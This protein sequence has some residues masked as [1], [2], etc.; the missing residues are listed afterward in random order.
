[1]SDKPGKN[2]LSFCV[3]ILLLIQSQMVHAVAYCALRDPVMAIQA[4]YPQYSSYR[5]LVGEVGPE[6]RSVLEQEIPYH[7]HFNEFGKH[8]LYLVFEGD[9]AAGLV[10]AR[11]EKGDWG[12]D[13]IVWSL[14]TDLSVRDFR[15]QRSRSRRRQAVESPEFRALLQG[16]GFSELTSLLSKDGSSLS[17]HYSF[18]PNDAEPLAATVILSALKTI[19]VTGSTWQAELAPYVAQRGHGAGQ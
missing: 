13:E 6:V 19:V 7:V 16:K 15:F 14:S 8:T 18:L 10:H 9:I 2:Y 3:T 5:S 12:L 4:F 17:Q 11:T 1:M